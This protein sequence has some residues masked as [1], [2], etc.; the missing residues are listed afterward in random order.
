VPGYL[1]N[2]YAT[3]LVGPYL[4]NRPIASIEAA[5]LLS[6][7]RRLEARGVRDTTHSVRA[8]VGRVFRHRDG[9]SEA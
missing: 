5:E 9:S 7:L 8:L 4:G 2:F 1:D 3:F 6:V